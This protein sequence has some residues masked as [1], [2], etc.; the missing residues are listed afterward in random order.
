MED[1]LHRKLERERRARKEAEALLESKSRQL[2]DTNQK[3]RAMTEELE[4]RVEERTQAL[5]QARDHAVD[6]ERRAEEF[7]HAKSRFLA[8]IS[9]EIRT[10]L[11]GI[12]GMA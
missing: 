10:P 3:L 5:R 11:N 4:R 1:L 8:N 7:S 6:A 2:W 12:L 9:H